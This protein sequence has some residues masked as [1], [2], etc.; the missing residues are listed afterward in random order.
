MKIKYLSHACFE[1]SDEKTLLIDPYFTGNN[2]AP[3]YEG[4]PD[5]ILVTHE[6]FDHF[7]KD[8]ISKFSCPVICPPSCKHPNAVVMKVGDKKVVEGI[9]I[10]MIQASHHQSSY[11]AGYIIEVEGRRICHLGDTYLDGVRKYE[12]IHV[13]FIPIGGKFTMDVDEAIEALRIIKPKL[14]IPMHYGTFAGIGADPS[15]FKSRAA[16]ERFEVRV[17]RIGE[18]IEV[19]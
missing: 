11:P 5:L 18:Q 16:K 1:I 12:N 13:L 2:L 10:E 15:E 9:P 8:F 4:K 6:H 17:M 3:K 19:K 14:A 7:D